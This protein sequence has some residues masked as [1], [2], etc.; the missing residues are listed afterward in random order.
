M[1]HGPVLFSRKNDDSGL[2]MLETQR[3]AEQLSSLWASL[4]DIDNAA[5]SGART[6]RT[7]QRCTVGVGAFDVNKE[8]V[9]SN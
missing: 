1:F 8:I 4:S 5:E 3:F 2:E 7:F 6:H 9:E